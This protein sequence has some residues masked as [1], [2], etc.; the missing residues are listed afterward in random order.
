MEIGVPGPVSG[1]LAGGGPSR[2]G[3]AAAQALAESAIRWPEPGPGQPLSAVGPNVLGRP[4]A[5][6]PGRL[7]QLLDAHADPIV[8]ATSPSSRDCA[9]RRALG[10][11]NQLAIDARG[12]PASKAGARGDPDTMA[13]SCGP[14]IPEVND[15]KPGLQLRV[16][17]GLACRAPALRGKALCYWHDPKRAEAADEAGRVGGNHR[18]KA[19]SVATIYD[20]SG[21]RTIEGAQRLLET[22]ALETLAL[23]NSIAHNRTLIS[24]AAG[25]GKLIESGDLDD[26]L[27]TVEAAVG[28]KAHEDKPPPSRGAAGASR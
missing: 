4:P 6:A 19:N 24:A 23:E 27:A 11:G 9:S 3:G 20:F 8:G 2:T 17:H 5:T 1:P 15:G 13:R 12:R 28:P 18:R 26:R 7:D 22:A 21:L 25:A 10:S 16:L 14:G